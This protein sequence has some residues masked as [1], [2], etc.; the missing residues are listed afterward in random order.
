MSW[1]AVNVLNA[2][3]EP[4][5]C[6]VSSPSVWLTY[7]LELIAM[8]MYPMRASFT[9]VCLLLKQT[10]RAEADTEGEVWKADSTTV[11]L[12][13]GLWSSQHV[14]QTDRQQQKKNQ[15]LC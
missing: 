2:M 10:R 1:G 5:S 7:N 9:H 12:R 8:Q 11:P 4:Y 15:S 3:T 13:F 6:S 14:T